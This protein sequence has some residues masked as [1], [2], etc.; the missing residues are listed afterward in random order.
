[1]RGRRG[2]ASNN[3]NAA[4]QCAVVCT[5]VGGMTNII[6]DGYNGLMVNPE[7]TALYKAIVS[8]IED[9]ALRDRLAQ[10]GYETVKNAFSY[11]IWRSKW[12]QV[13]SD[14]RSK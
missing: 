4:T 3:S 12:T 13:L 10:R 9:E 1:M 8:L 7:E 11:E 6:L 2:L 5:N 14:L